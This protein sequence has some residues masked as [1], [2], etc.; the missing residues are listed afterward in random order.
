MTKKGKK[1]WDPLNLNL[2][3]D[4]D[5][6]IWD[7]DEYYYRLRR[8]VS[9]YFI[10]EDYIYTH[11]KNKKD[12]ISLLNYHL[13]ELYKDLVEEKNGIDRTYP[14]QFKK[15]IDSEEVYTLSLGHFI[16]H[17]IL[18]NPIF[19]L[20]ELPDLEVDILQPK[21]MTTRIY[22]K[23]MNTIIKRYKNK[24]DVFSLSEYFAETYDYF[25]EI[26]PIANIY[27]E[28]KQNL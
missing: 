13:E 26:L 9:E 19:Q 25:R 22:E 27:E 28:P 18:W 8:E 10:L 17:L 16:M 11:K 7:E 3:M 2:L 1:K 5:D 15:H 4:D 20:N 12:P 21:V 24:I 6:S 23:F 14:I